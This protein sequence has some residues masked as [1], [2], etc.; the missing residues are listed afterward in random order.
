MH[1]TGKRKQYNPNRQR[2]SD[3]IK[4]TCQLAAR[5]HR[6]QFKT[7]PAELKCHLLSLMQINRS[8]R[9]DV[10]QGKLATLACL[11]LFSTEQPRGS[12][13]LSKEMTGQPDT[14]YLPTACCD[15]IKCQPSDD[16]STFAAWLSLYHRYCDVNVL[17]PFFKEASAD[18]IHT[19][20]CKLPIHILLQLRGQI[21]SR[22]NIF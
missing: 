19:Q 15:P 13:Q 11:V 9:R 2:F 1:S 21:V 3:N 16:F 18:L 10:G 17:T 5:T 4:H 8:Q 6:L 7:M 20:C 12:N 22:M 14:V